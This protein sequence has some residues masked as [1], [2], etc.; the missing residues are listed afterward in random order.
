MDESIRDSIAAASEYLSAH[1]DEA[2]YTDSVA[3]AVADGLRTTVTGAAGETLV[4][5]MPRSV[6]G[7]DAAPSPGWMLRAAISSCV[8]T[9]IAMRAAVKEIDLSTL[10]VTVDSESDDRG[11]LGLEDAVPAGPLSVRV[12]VRISSVGTSPEELDGIV[13][14]AFLHCPVSDAVQRAVPMTLEIGL[15]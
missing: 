2:R 14:W 3:R 8:A 11:I 7:G 1:P 13:K 10:E 4:T 12:H 9:L 6:G 15:D 5:D